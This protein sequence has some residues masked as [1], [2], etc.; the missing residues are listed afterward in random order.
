MADRLSFGDLFGVLRRHWL[1]F[2]V[3]GVAAVLL[4]WIFSGTTF[5]KPRFRS[6]ATVYPVNL[7]SY[8]EE[9][10]TDQLLQLLESNSIRDSLIARFHLAERYHV[11]TT[12]K[13]WRFVLFNLVKER[14]DIS[15]TRYES[16][17]IEVEDEDATTARDMVQAMLDQTDRLARRLQREKSQELLVIARG[18]LDRAQHKLDSVERRLDTLRAGGLLNY[19]GQTKELVKGYVKMLTSG[20]SNAQKDE[21]RGMMRTMEEK[22]GEFRLLMELSNI[23]RAD[24]SKYLSDYE[25]LQV[26]V[27]KMLTYT[28]TVIHPEVAD[29]KIFPVRWLIVA[30]SLVSALFLCFLFYAYND[31]SGGRQPRP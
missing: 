9:S 12:A 15:K 30:V 20:A 29:H 21:V 14:I 23:F 10:R 4:A 2:A 8:S 31:L 5:I 13:G 1:S 18:N 28:N 26:D 24:Y 27:S 16:V 6:T 22:G 7:T 3:V 11:D 25:Q 19:D 17:Q